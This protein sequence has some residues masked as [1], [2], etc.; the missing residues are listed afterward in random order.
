MRR[1]LPNVAAIIGTYIVG[2]PVAWLL[3]VATAPREDA[4]RIYLGT[5][6]VD[7]ILGMIAGLAAMA[8]SFVSYATSRTQP[9]STA[10]MRYGAD[11]VAISFT[12]LLLLGLFAQL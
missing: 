10:Y 12:L 6:V 4:H 3:F 9:T 7:L 8:W 2:L 1:P 5:A 11:M